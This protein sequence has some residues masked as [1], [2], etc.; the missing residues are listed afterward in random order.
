MFGNHY[1]GFGHFCKQERATPWEQVQ[2]LR[3]GGLAEDGRTQNKGMDY[4]SR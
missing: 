2:Q 1:A 3:Q 4:G